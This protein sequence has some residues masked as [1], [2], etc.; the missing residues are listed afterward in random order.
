MLFVQ[1][2]DRI[3]SDGRGHANPGG[4]GGGGV[5]GLMTCYDT[6]VMTLLS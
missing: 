4:A 6:S 5:E 3:L 2:G 1:T